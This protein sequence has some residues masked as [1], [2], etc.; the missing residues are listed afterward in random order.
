MHDATKQNAHYAE[1]LTFI[2][3][4]LPS[5]TD[6]ALEEIAEARHTLVIAATGAEIPPWETL[7]SV[8]RLYERVNVV[9]SLAAFLQIVHAPDAEEGQNEE[10]APDSN[11]RSWPRSR[12]GDGVA[13]EANR[14]QEQG[15]SRDDQR[16][17]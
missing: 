10:Q 4:R 12:E 3:A 13:A 11:A 15:R 17:Q 5:F 1:T 7:D 2:R 8:H 14:L 6:E 9:Y 16:D